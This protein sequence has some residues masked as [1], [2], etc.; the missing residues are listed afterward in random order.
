MQETFVIL[1]LDSASL[2]YQGIGKRNEKET[3]TVNTGD[4]GWA[5]EGILVYP[6]DL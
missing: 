4:G 3:T 6:P 1:P 2:S 5:V